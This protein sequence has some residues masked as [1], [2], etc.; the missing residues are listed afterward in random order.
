MSKADPGIAVSLGSAFLGYYAHTGFLNGLNEQGIFPGKICGASAGALV[1]SLYASGMQGDEL[2][3]FILDRELKK[4]F[5]DPGFLYRW[6]PMLFFGQPTGL[7]NGKRAIKFLEE[8]LP[9]SKIEDCSKAE[10]A[11]AVSNLRKKICPILQEG[12]LAQAISAS[13]SVPGLFGEQEIA[14]ERY[15][16]GGILH[17]SPLDH[18]FPDDEIHTIIVH[19]VDYPNPKK[20]H[21]FVH[22][23]FTASHDMF[24]AEITGYRKREAEFRGKRL[25]FCDT[26]H[27]H[28]GLLQ[29]QEKK[30][31]FY[32]KGCET[33]REI[34]LG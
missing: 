30:E 13:C 11:I 16:D 7:L 3:K 12:P 21:F 24:S 18:Y 5:I 23:I 15:F 29:S 25:I 19:R 14:G 32:E 4:A 8:S 10:L 20:K 6:I 17:E 27:P 22:D 28:P 31:A 33:G 9:V 1:A 34:E 26:H 2:R